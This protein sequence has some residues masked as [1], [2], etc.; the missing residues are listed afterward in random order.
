MLRFRYSNAEGAGNCT[1]CA[2]RPMRAFLFVA[3][4]TALFAQP[5]LHPTDHLACARDKL[6]ERDKRLPDYTCIQ[7]VDR[8]YFKRLPRR[9]TV[10]DGDVVR[11]KEIAVCLVAARST[12]TFATARRLGGCRTS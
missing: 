1:R 5:P 3:V 12:P 2:P 10:L 11:A 7:A 6:V 8:R 4:G 9:V